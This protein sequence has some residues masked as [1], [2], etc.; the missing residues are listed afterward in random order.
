MAFAFRISNR[1]NRLFAAGGT[2]WSDTTNA[3]ILV[4]DLLFARLSCDNLGAV[5]AETT[6]VTSIAVG[7]QAFTKVKEYTNGQGA[8]SAGVTLS[9]WV[10]QN[11]AAVSAGGAVQVEFSGSIPAN[12]AALNICA[13]TMDNTKM[14]AVTDSSQ[15]NATDGVGDVGDLAVAGLPSAAYLGVRAV[16][17]EGSNAAATITGGWTN[18]PG[19][20]GGGTSQGGEFLI[21]TATGFSSDGFTAGS[22]FDAVSILMVFEESGAAP[23]APT[24]TSQEIGRDRRRGRSRR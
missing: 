2:S 24:A 11:S 16:G 1:V 20:G 14:L 3:S 23:P 9:V 8:P 21:A 4:G 22:A 17:W 7:G 13:F 18:H 10:L 5:D 15:F 12:T 19:T 6:T